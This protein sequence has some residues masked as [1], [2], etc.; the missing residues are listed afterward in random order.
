[1]MPALERGAGGSKTGWW[2]FEMG[3]GA[4]KWVP[5]GRKRASDGLGVENGP[6]VGETLGWDSICSNSC[7]TTL[8]TEKNL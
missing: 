3:G 8:V 5:V 2:W 1:M 6:L 7:K 4:G